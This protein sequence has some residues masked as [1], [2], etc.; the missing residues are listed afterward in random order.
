MA[1]V[2]RSAARHVETLASFDELRGRGAGDYVDASGRVRAPEATVG[3]ARAAFARFGITRVADVTGLDRIGIPVTMV[4]RPNARSLAVS[5]GKGRDRVAAQASGIM[6]SIE[7][8]TAEHVT[9]PTWMAPY[10]ELAASEQRLLEPTELPLAQATNYSPDLVL[11]WMAGID[12]ATGDATLVP[13]ELVHA[14]AL[15][16]MVPGTGTFVRSTNGLASGNCPGEA[17]LHGVCEVIERDAL[18]LFEHSSAHQRSERKVD[19]DSVGDGDPGQLLRR[20]EDA[21]I[22][23]QIWDIT[24]DVGVAAFR[25]VI[26]DRTTNPVLNPAPAAFGAGCHPRRAVALTRALTEAAQSRLTAISGSRDDLTRAKYRSFQDAE[27]LRGH[28]EQ[29]DVPGTRDYQ[30]APDLCCASLEH[31][32]TAVLELLGRRE[33]GPVVAV[34]LSEPDV[35]WAVVRTIATGLEGPT[36]SPHYRPGARARRGGLPS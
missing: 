18:A 15:L 3:D 13:F 4:V 11:P 24:S 29:A 2:A 7:L 19:R 26:V 8:A 35:P 32:I 1:A 6:E 22:D 20:F 23:V 10:E 14:N 9:G 17:V 12:L 31:D 34:D 33:L 36:E 25:V 5:Q 30:A 16:P 27:A 28:L 21:D